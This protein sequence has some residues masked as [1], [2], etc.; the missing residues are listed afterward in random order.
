[1]A[2]FF[3]IVC[4]VGVIFL[5]YW[6]IPANPFPKPSGEWSVG[7]SDLIWDSSNHTGII[8]KI[9]YPINATTGVQ[10]PYIDNIDRTLAVIT[11]GF[12][13]L[14]NLIFNQ[15]YLDRIWTPALIDAIPA[16]SQDGF[17]AILFSPG[18]CS[19]N[20]MYTFYA[21]EF[22]SHGFVVI[23]INHPGSS[24]CTLLTD[25]SKVEFNKIDKEILEDIKLLEEYSAPI[26][27]QQAIDISIVL[28]KVLQLNSNTNSVLHQIVNINK[29]FT[30]GHSFGGA[31]SFIAC[32]KDER[33]SKSI[34]LDGVFLDEIDV[35]YSKTE[36]LLAHADR[37]RYRPKNKK[38]QSNYDSMVSRDKIRLEQLSFKA[39]LTHLK[40]NLANHFNFSDLSIII[41]PI[42]TKTIGL[43]G[44]TDG[45]KLLSQ[46]SSMMIDFFNKQT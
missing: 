23:G 24:A 46:T 33:I 29:I 21:L 28:D 11:T 40:F 35:D 6:I 32:R 17:P 41:K 18:S 25:G 42:L 30:A 14:S 38:M 43:V 34:N 12:N 16:Q 31:A 9:W 26:M 5:P 13:P 8:A 19:M 20:F 39:N 15:F 45:L 4:I 2:I 3:I 27:A 1:M 37:D 22:A 44:K 7:T 36:L 10:S